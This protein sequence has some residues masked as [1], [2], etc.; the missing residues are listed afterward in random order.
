MWDWRLVHS[1]YQQ[2][3]AIHRYHK[4]RN[5]VAFTAEMA[6]VLAF[7]GLLKL[8]ISES[9][10]T[11]QEYR[12]NI[13]YWEVFNP[14]SSDGRQTW[15]RKYISLFLWKLLSVASGKPGE[16][17]EAVIMSIWRT[18][19][20]WG[21]WGSYYQEH[22]ETWITWRTWGSCYYEHLENL[23]NL[24][25]LLSGASGEPGEPGEPGEA[26]IMSIWRTW[27]TWRHCY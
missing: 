26:L 21:S 7:S 27:V 1:S 5:P 18:W 12:P 16:P 11:W 10:L 24:G 15:R 4:N 9:F 25:K 22:L 8:E 3:A 17:G 6:R 23:E 13:S 20:S 14:T 19:G 2:G